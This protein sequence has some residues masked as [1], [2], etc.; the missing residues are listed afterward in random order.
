[1]YSWLYVWSLTQSLPSKT[2]DFAKW[3]ELGNKTKGWERRMEG[4]LFSKEIKTDGKR[5]TRW[6]RNAYTGAL[7]PP[8]QT[9]SYCQGKKHRKYTGTDI[10]SSLQNVC[11]S[12][13]KP[14]TWRNG[15]EAVC[16]KD[17][18][19]EGEGGEEVPIALV[20]LVVELNPVQTKG[21]QEGRESLDTDHE[22]SKVNQRSHTDSHPR[23]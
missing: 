12:K 2:F 7:I 11:I 20:E 21:M 1:M 10:R 5:E 3:I 8:S 4:W 17:N 14:H 16:G 22:V 9:E 23:L 15:N 6:C 19:R 13:D 18:L